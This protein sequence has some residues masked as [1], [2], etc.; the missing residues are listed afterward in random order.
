VREV[1][2]PRLLHV[3]VGHKFPNYFENATR[4]VLHMTTDDILVV[5]NAS[6]DP[7]VSRRL[8]AIADAE[9]RVQLMLRTTN[10][11]ARN[12][13]VGGLYD[14]YNEVTAYTLDHG[15]DYMHIL[16]HDMQMLWWDQAVTSCAVEIF[17]E[18]PECVNIQ[19]LINYRLLQL[20]DELECLKPKLM[21]YTKYGLTD[22]GLY[23]MAKWRAHGMRFGDTERAHARKYLQQG[24]RVFWHPLPTVAPIPWPAVVRGGRIVGQEIQP[25][26]QFILRPLSSA[27]TARVMESADPVWFEDVGVPWG[28]TCLTPYWVSDLRSINYLVYLYRSIRRHG[29]RA[30]WPTWERR[31]L[32]AGTRLRSVQ[33]QPRLGMLAVVA[34]PMWHSLRQAIKKRR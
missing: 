4:S 34:V 32:A 13:K 8:K 22:T 33:R 3:I 18:Y 21:F 14:A 28:W 17:E 30:A 5:D 16:Q 11:I 2:P 9:P 26:H 6:N 20:S 15:Y 1:T 7:G 25:R 12:S 19:T 31:G 27:E 23:D 29:L 24:F 10:D